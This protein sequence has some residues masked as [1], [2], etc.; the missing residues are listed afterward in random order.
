MSEQKQTNTGSHSNIIHMLTTKINQLNNDRKRA[1]I[2]VVQSLTKYQTNEIFYL[3]N[4]DLPIYTYID[5]NME[6]VPAES[7]N[8][9]MCYDTI[10]KQLA[11]MIN[12]SILFNEIIKVSKAI[13]YK[14]SKK[15][16]LF[17]QEE[18]SFET[19]QIDTLNRH[20]LIIALNNLIQQRNI[21]NKPI[22]EQE[23]YR[24][25]QQLIDIERTYKCTNLVQLFIS[26]TPIEWHHLNGGENGLEC[27]HNLHNMISLFI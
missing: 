23:E 7:R 10:N 18:M 20:F 27:Y 6:C 22:Q 14:M 24:F 3:F 5:R 25:K 8:I 26:N 15:F 12:S 19:D 13:K 17:L 2:R 21:Y 1:F 4:S 16:A 11:I 9:N